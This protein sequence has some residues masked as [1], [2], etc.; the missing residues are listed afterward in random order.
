MYLPNRAAALDGSRSYDDHGIVEY[1]WSRD[2]KSPAAGV[3]ISMMING[4]HQ[5]RDSCE[6]LPASFTALQE[7]KV[8]NFVQAVTS[9]FG[10]TFALICGPGVLILFPCPVWNDKKTRSEKKKENKEKVMTFVNKVA[11]SFSRMLPVKMSYSKDSNFGYF[12]HRSNH[13]IS[14]R[15]NYTKL[16]LC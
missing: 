13:F 3:S 15:L 1:E 14:V 8:G 9:L 7:K 2:P 5:I 10:D 12:K 6:L 16:Y 11:I 4:H